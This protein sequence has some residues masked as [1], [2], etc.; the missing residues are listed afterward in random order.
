MYAF[1]VDHPDPPLKMNLKEWE[2][3]QTVFSVYDS[4]LGGGAISVT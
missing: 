1:N 3:T 2:R 4:D